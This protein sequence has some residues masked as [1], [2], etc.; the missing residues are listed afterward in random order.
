M[1]STIV[2]T[3]TLKPEAMEPHLALIDGVSFIHISTADTADSTNPLPALASF[4]AF[5]AGLPDR[6][7][8]RPTPSGADIIAS[9]PATA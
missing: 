5:S 3:Y 1:T 8:S 9:Y 2:V 6:V 4:R 7:A